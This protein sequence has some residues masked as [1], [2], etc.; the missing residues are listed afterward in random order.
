VAQGHSA[1]RPVGQAVLDPP[2]GETAVVEVTEVLQAAANGCHGGLVEVLTVEVGEDLVPAAGAASDQGQGR[3]QAPGLG[4]PGQEPG[5]VVGAKGA[6][7]LKAGR[8]I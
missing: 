3:L 4:V 7:P 8:D 1:P 6:P 5:Y 2:P